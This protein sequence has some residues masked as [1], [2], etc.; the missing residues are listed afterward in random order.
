D[1]GACFLDVATDAGAHFDHRL[2]HLGL[3]LFAQQ[4]LAFFEYLGDVRAQLARLRID[5]LK[6]LFD[7]QCK[8]I[9]HWPSFQFGFKC[10]LIS[11]SCA[12]RASLFRAARSES[13]SAHWRASGPDYK[14]RSAQPNGA[15]HLPEI[16]NAG[17]LRFAASHKNRR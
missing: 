10:S 12:S 6:F 4:H 2:D 17:S 7:T 9:E 5:D 16:E 3:D 13:A 15:A 11:R 14:D 8:L 1:I